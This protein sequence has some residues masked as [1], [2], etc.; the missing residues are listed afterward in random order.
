M[1]ITIT[2]PVLFLSTVL[3]SA[4]NVW[5]CKKGKGDVI[6]KEMALETF[7]SIVVDGSMEVLLSRSTVQEVNVEGQS[8]L[9]DLVELSVKD[10]VLHVGTSKCY[11]SDR[12]FNVMVAI[13]TVEAITVR[14]SGSVRNAGSFTVPHLIL[15]VSGSGDVDLQV[16][17]RRISALLD[18]SGGIG[19]KGSCAALAA[20]V[21]GSGGISAANLVCSTVTAKLYGSGDITVDV[22]D[23]LEAD[24]NGSGTI[25]YRN[26]PAGIEQRINGSGSIKQIE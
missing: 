18:G 17:A 12:P 22:S 19:L 2:L 13:P 15:E 8:N 5:N 11:N 4:C 6:R 7:S 20:T 1:R 14:G 25:Q 26:E 9:I 21:Q 24:V 10:G 3:L 16:D 23:R